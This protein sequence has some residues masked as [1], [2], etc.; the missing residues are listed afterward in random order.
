MEKEPQ[1]VPNAPS[2]IHEQV[3][4]YLLDEMDDTER[5]RLDE[6]LVSAPEFSDTIASIEDDL[7]MQYIRGDLDPRLVSRFN[8]V[9]MSSPSKRAR[10]DAARVLQQA[11]RE[12]AQIRSRERLRRWRLAS[13]LAAAAAVILLLAV[14]WPYWNKRPPAPRPGE[15]AGAEIMAALQPGLLRSGSGVSIH[16]PQAARIRF[17]LALANPASGAAYRAIVGTPEHPDV[18]HGA[19]DLQGE[20]I[21]TVMPAGVLSRGDYILELQVKE[22]PDTWTRAASYYFRVER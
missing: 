10:V 6:R 1:P 5:N 3:V 9:Y 13:P 18:W 2:G 4:R 14:L 16:L 15:S 21:V 19:A 8:E 12:A 11:V 17:E 22:R 20:H 7:I